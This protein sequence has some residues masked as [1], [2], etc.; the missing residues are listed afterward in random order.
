M[1]SHF[2]MCFKFGIKTP[3]KLRDM[4]W[5]RQIWP[6]I[7]K[8]QRALIH[9][10]LH[11]SVWNLL[12]RT[13]I[14]STTRVPSKFRSLINCEIQLFCWVKTSHFVLTFCAY[15][16]TFVCNPQTSKQQRTTLYEHM[17][18]WLVS[19]RRRLTTLLYISWSKMTMNMFHAA[20]TN[21]KCTFFHKKHSV[22][23]EVLC[24]KDLPACSSTKSQNTVLIKLN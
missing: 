12:S 2:P 9:L 15:P 8:N 24:F 4:A 16:S 19:C 22:F 21:T 13:D 20:I 10:F 18:G 1:Q 14:Y 6:V 7:W 23:H 5:N 11:Q 3:N 17:M